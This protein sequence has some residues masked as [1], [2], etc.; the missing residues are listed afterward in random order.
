MSRGE[1]VHALAPIMMPSV[2]QF[3]SPLVHCAPTCPPYCV[4]ISSKY[5]K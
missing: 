2:N 5:L 1:C 4:K 3:G